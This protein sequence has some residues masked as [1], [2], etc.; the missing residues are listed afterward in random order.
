MWI[1]KL[2]LRRLLRGPAI[3]RR[4][5]ISN[6]GIRITPRVVLEN[7]TVGQWPASNDRRYLEV[8]G[9]HNQ[10]SPYVDS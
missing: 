3:L 1:A 8:L 10:L 6:E 7:L 2:A 9:T 4:E 5:P